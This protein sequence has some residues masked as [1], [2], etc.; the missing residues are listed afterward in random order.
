MKK[1][2]GTAKTR[3]QQKSLRFSTAPNLNWKI[4]ADVGTALTSRR[5]DNGTDNAFAAHSL[6]GTINEKQVSA[7]P[8]ADTIC[9]PVFSTPVTLKF[10]L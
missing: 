5:H 1:N 10:T 8:M 2:L 7:A 6:R 3:K 4:I 9:G